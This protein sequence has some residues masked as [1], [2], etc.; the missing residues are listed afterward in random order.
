MLR[1]LVSVLLAFVATSQAHAASGIQAV[2]EDKLTI[3]FLLVNIFLAIY[4]AFIRF[5]RF[6]VQHGPEVLT[7][8]GIFGCFLGISMA[9]MN[10]DAGDV[11]ASVPHLLE[12]VR[13]AFLASVSG[14]AGSLLIRAR[15][16]F[17][18]TPI[19][20]STGAPKSANLDDVVQALQSLQRGLSGDE[21]GSLLSQMKLMRQG[22]SD[23]L[24]ALRNSFETFAS[25]MA[26]DGSKALIEALKD[27]IRDF[28][29]QLEE[30]FGQNFKE[31]NAAVEK[32]VIWQQQYKNELDQMQ[33]VQRAAAEDLRK[34]AGG[35]S[36]L[37]ERS[38]AFTDS[39]NALESLLQ[40][41]GQQY[42][43]IEQSQRSLATVLVEMKDVAPQFAAKLDELAESMKY[44]VSRVQAEVGEVVKN[45]GTQV[46]SSQAEMKQLLTETLKQSQKLV[47]DE[48]LK[49]LDTVR[50]SVVTLDQGL[51]EELTKSLETM[52]RQLASLSEKFVAD[53][54][55]LTERLREVVRMAGQV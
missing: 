9:L 13:T 8:I 33:S 16:H 38:E 55:P 36:V 7:T 41:L 25:K 18:K 2:L 11:S 27:V 47:N 29:T 52:G 44:G 19:P 54:L 28:N 14:V 1:L 6:A 42:V 39:A 50:E 4:F 43:M 35:L 24:Q 53:Y 32:L 51:Q 21:D 3:F 12:G 5:N 34:S 48:L 10:F 20:Q 23:Q 49:G 40:G 46:Q 31:L 45:L 22:Q 17:H 37:A 15:H 30:Q 26:E